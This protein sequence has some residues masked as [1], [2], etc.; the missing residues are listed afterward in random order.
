MCEPTVP[1]GFEI[2]IGKGPHLQ[3]QF[4]IID[5]LGKIC[6]IRESFIFRHK[7]PETIEDLKNLVIYPIGKKY[8]E[9]PDKTI[10][11]YIYGLQYKYDTEIEILEINKLESD[12][13]EKKIYPP[14]FILFGVK[15]TY[16]CINTDVHSNNS[17]IFKKINYTEDKKNIL[18]ISLNE[19]L[20][21]LNKCND[22]E[23]FKETINI[24]INIINKVKNNLVKVKEENKI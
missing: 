22:Y 20:T 14:K 1:N 3:L 23:V 5:D 12:I 24:K 13:E 17:Y 18:S 15:N 8:L 7:I 16:N 11:F 4:I 6:S 10:G 2:V 19:S 21:K 9:I